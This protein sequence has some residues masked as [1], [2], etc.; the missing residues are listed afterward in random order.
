MIQ[1]TVGCLGIGLLA[2]ATALD[3]DQITGSTSYISGL[4]TITGIALLTALG[5][6]R[7][8]ASLHLKIFSSVMAVAFMSANLSNLLPSDNFTV[9]QLDLTHIVASTGCLTSIVGLWYFLEPNC[10]AS[11]PMASIS[12]HE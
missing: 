9:A 2:I 3:L 11:V 10:K 12:Q 5:R 4:V 6:K 7:Q 8:Q 1:L